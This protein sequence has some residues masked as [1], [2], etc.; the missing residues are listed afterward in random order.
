VATQDD[1]N[2]CPPDYDGDG[3]IDAEDACPHIAGPASAS[4]DTN[5]CPAA[6]IEAGEIKISERIEFKTNSATLLPSST[7]TLQ[8][9]LAILQSHAEITKLSVEGHTDSVGK[10]TRNQ[11]LSE[12]RAAA[13]KTWLTKHGVAKARLTSRGFGAARPID[14]SDTSEARDRNRRVEFH[15]SEQT[16]GTPGN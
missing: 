15:V 11:V 6:R 12:R 3:V 2:G 13:V 4:R 7:P 9:V 1:R 14:P 5:G 16:A 8:A 10:A